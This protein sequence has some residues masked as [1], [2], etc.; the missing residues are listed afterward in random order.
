MALTDLDSSICYTC[1]KGRVVGVRELISIFDIY[2]F[3]CT[4]GHLVLRTKVVQYMPNTFFI[5]NFCA[6]FKTWT[7]HVF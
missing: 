6:H 2:I 4:T 3:F 7:S 1:L 5:L